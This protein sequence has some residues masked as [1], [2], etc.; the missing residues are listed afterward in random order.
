MARMVL[1]DQI[2]MNK[3]R[4]VYIMAMMFILIGL[5]VYAM[6][7]VVGAF[8]FFEGGPPFGFITVLAMIVAGLYIWGTFHWSVKEVIR[9]TGARPANP[10]VREEKLLI[11]KVE[12]L[13]LAAGH[14]PPPTVYVVDSK[15]INAFATGKK[16]EDSIIAVTTG[17]MQKLNQ[18]E[19][20]GVLAHELAHIRN[21]DVLLTTTTIAVVGTI[22]ILSEMLIRFVFYGSIMGRGGGGRGGGGGPAILVLVVIAIV[23]AILAPLFARLTYLALS[24]K[25]EYL[26][27]VTGAHLTRNPGGLASALRKIKAEAPSDPKGSPTAA[28]LYF[29]NPFKRARKGNLWATH[30][31][32]EERIRRLE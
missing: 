15:D 27:D 32:L 25:R 29:A 14:N 10:E 17:L 18:E 26:A 1:E 28:G 20:E 31:P 23:F 7:V 2:A 19:M 30:P 22:A 11:W 12:E 24:R 8:F 5:L 4:T 13:S 3:R 16:P 21:R 9:A 6:A